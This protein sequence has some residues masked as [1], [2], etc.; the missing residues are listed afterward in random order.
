M[1]TDRRIISDQS[2]DNQL[3]AQHVYL[4][5]FE[6]FLKNSSNNYNHS[7][8]TSYE[9]FHRY[10]SWSFMAANPLPHEFF[11][12]KCC[13][14]PSYHVVLALFKINLNKRL[15]IKVCSFLFHRQHTGR[16]AP[17][18]FLLVLPCTHIQVYRYKSP[19][20]SDVDT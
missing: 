12:Y 5:S 4:N 17:L 11:Y 6:G 9:Y 8:I 13:L 18:Y 7:Y 3:F 1:L 15:A 16:L 2:A 20:I 10:T 14:C 19:T